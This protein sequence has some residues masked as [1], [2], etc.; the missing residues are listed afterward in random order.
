MTP[1]S[2]KVAN[3]IFMLTDIPMAIMAG[4]FVPVDAT[5]QPPSET[6]QV[7]VE[8]IVKACPADQPDVQADRPPIQPG[9]ELR[10][11]A[12]ANPAEREAA[13]TA[14]HCILQPHFGTFAEGALVARRRDQIEKEK[15][16]SNDPIETDTCA[17]YGAV[18]RPH[19]LLAHTGEGNTAVEERHRDCASHE[20]PR[21]G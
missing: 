4:L 8:L 18:A 20:R 13:F 2:L 3:P 15:R 21:L 6:P 10:K 14:M 1:F 12:L 11:R 9:K 5:A 19:P 16:Q 7:Y 17:C